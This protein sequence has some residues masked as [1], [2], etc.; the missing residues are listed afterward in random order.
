MNVAKP[1]DGIGFP[2]VELRAIVSRPAWVLG[3]GSGPPEEQQV[4]SAT[5]HPQP[6][7]SIF[8]NILTNSPG[9]EL[10]L[11]HQHTFLFLSSMETLCVKS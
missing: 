5:G 4:F 11:I 8:L 2:G 1:E 6:V 3:T 10:I 7:S 9:E